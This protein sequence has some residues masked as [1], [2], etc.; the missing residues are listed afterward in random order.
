MVVIG[1][2]G[3]FRARVSSPEHPKPAITTRADDQR[4]K[5]DRA[6]ELGVVPRRRPDP[7]A[8]SRQQR[9]TGESAIPRWT[10]RPH[11]RGRGGPEP[12][13]RCS[14]PS[15]STAIN[16]S[17]NA[18]SSRYRRPLSDHRDT[19]PR[20]AGRRGPAARAPA[21]PSEIRIGYRTAGVPPRCP[22][23]RASRGS[24]AAAFGRR[25]GSR[26]SSARARRGRPTRS[27]SC[28]RPTS[29]VERRALRGRE[30]SPGVDR[31]ST[32]RSRS[33]RDGR[34]ARRCGSVGHE[35]VG[36][37]V[38]GCAGSSPQLR[39][40]VAAPRRR[41]RRRAGRRRASATRDRPPEQRGCVHVGEQPLEP[42]TA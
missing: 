27:T 1:D 20:V 12:A 35:H 15:Y 23:R 38:G 26:R 41:G 37:F 22:L 34:A 6:A 31:H 5:P 3:S 28:G 30:H 29:E 19:G 14:A 8:T 9:R 25:P 4:P 7:G 39:R 13:A 11:A 10:G 2:R 33:R 42:W 24:G 18:R 16:S 21:S 40:C 32:R 36:R 17:G